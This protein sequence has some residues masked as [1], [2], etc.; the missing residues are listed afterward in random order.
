MDK[1]VVWT[2]H[3]MNAFTGGC[4]YSCGC[5]K[6]NAM[7]SQCPQLGPG[8][9]SDPAQY[10]WEQ[11]RKAYSSLNITVVTPSRWLADCA[12]QSSLLNRFPVHIIPYGLP[13]NIFKPL[14]SQ[15]FRERHNISKKVKIVLFG[16]AGVANKRKGFFYLLQALEKISLVN[17]D[18]E[19]IFMFFGSFSKGVNLNIKHP[20]LQ[21]GYIN[22]ESILA[23]IY[24]CSDIVV[25][26]SVEDNLP[27]IV[28]EAMASGTPVVGFAT[29][30]IPDMIIDGQTGF[31]S[32][33]GSVDDLAACIGK[34]LSNDDQRKIISE[35]CRLKAIS[36]YDIKGQAL[37]YHNL[38][39]NILTRPANR[40]S[41]FNNLKENSI[42]INKPD[43]TSGLHYQFSQPPSGNTEKH[44]C[45]QPVSFLG[46]RSHPF[47][48]CKITKSD[49]TA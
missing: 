10:A 17:K 43:A 28:L 27:N 31:L 23:E 7:C 19:L 39:E 41:E 14:P 25:V 1:P 13:L 30:G 20:V 3:D 16:A 47:R 11:K 40:S 8:V 46:N 49:R 5:N 4:H 42:N 45:V 21:L 35:N 12:R 15:S 26:P 37:R 29:G 48:P 2:L 33:T 9:C 22:D 36:E 38:Y 18:Q 34:M 32:Q 44:I 6:F 24:S